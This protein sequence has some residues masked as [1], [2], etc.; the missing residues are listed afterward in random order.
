MNLIRHVG[1]GSHP[2]LA[3][4]D[5]DRLFSLAGGGGLSVP[6]DWAPR[7]DLYEEEQRYVVKAELAGVPK[8]NV[9]VTL[10]DGVLCLSGERQREVVHDRPGGQHVE[11][12]FGR[13]ERQ[14]G[15]PENIVPEQV[16]AEFKDGLLTITIPKRE[17]AKPKRIDVS[18]N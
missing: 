12:S 14:V 10:E 11:R 4:A 1:F 9:K 7:M 2:W 18:L 8:E 15:L 3:L 5:M 16:K 6:A 17:S 13:F